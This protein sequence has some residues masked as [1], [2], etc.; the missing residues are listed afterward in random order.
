MGLRCY[1][2]CSF[3]SK[4]QK[5][6]WTSLAT[7]APCL[8]PAVHT[9]FCCMQSVHRSQCILNQF[10]NMCTV[11]RPSST[12]AVAWLRS[13]NTREDKEWWDMIPC[14]IHTTTNSLQPSG[15]QYATLRQSIIFSP[16]ASTITTGSSVSSCSY[17]CWS[18]DWTLSS[19]RSYTQITHAKPQTS[20]VPLCSVDLTGSVT[21][22]DCHWKWAWPWHRV[23]VTF[24][25]RHVMHCFEALMQTFSVFSHGFQH[26]VSQFTFCRLPCFRLENAAKFF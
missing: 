5:S 25:D 16:R 26:S 11:S 20:T 4:S 24:Q 19:D 21:Y 7:C 6:Y 8:D 17:V 18:T 1:C 23:A 22:I 13:L 12:P 10:A 2:C 15:Q 3:L 14:G 9:G